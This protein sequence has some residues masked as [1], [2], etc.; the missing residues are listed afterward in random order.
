[1]TW[2]VRPSL[3]G[4]VG[5]LSGAFYRDPELA[6]RPVFDRLGELEIL[7]EVTADEAPASDMTL[8]H[9]L[10]DLIRKGTDPETAEPVGGVMVAASAD[11]EVEDDLAGLATTGSAV[12][13]HGEV[14]VLLC[15]LGGTAPL[16]TFLRYL[17]QSKGFRRLGRKVRMGLETE[18]EML[19]RRGRIEIR[20]GIVRLS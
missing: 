5:N 7:Q 19:A 14:E 8:I 4:S 11:E 9:E 18:L 16:E 15:K 3:N 10:D 1:M 6:M 2:H 17:A 13:D 12:F 20:S